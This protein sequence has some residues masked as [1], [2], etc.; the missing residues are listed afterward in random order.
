MAKWG[1]GAQGGQVSRVLIT[2]LNADPASASRRGGRNRLA[3]ASVQYVIGTADLVTLS[4]CIIAIFRVRGGI[5]EC[6]QIVGKICGIYFWL[7]SK[8]KQDTKVVYQVILNVQ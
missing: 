7:F 3:L 5:R 8:F 2:R 4:I 1:L 6:G